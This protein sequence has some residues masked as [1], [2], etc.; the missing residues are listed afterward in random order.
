MASIGRL[1]AGVAH[2]INN[3]LAIINE[4]GGLMM[5]YLEQSGGVADRERFKEL[6]SSILRNVKRCRDITH[7]L[8]GFARQV[9]VERETIDILWVINEVLGFLGKEAEYRNVTIH[10]DVPS[11]LP[12]ISSDRGQVQQMFLNIINNALQAVPDGGRIDIF[13]R[14]NGKD[15]VDITFRDNGPG[16]PREDLRLIFEPFFS[17]KGTEGTGLGLSITYGIARKLGGDI[18]VESELGKGAA[19]TV[20]LPVDRDGPS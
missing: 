5:D 14:W 12:T 2:E 15:K 10:L 8:L 13:G 18:S 17:T 4:K 9:T 1:A 16:I 20:T 7:R 19:F 6:A 3:P 11:D